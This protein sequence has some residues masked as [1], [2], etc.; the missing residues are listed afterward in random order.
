YYFLSQWLRLP[1]L[2]DRSRGYWRGVLNRILFVRPIFDAARYGRR[3]RMIYLVFGLLSFVYNVA[4]ALLILIFVGG[5]LIDRFYLL[6]LLLAAGIGLI[7]MRRPISQTI[8]MFVVPAS[9][10][11]AILRSIRLKPGLQTKEDK[12]ADDNQTTSQTSEQSAGKGSRSPFWR[13][14]LVPLSIALLVITVLLAPW[15]ASV[16][17]YG[18]LVAIPAREA[19]IRAPESATLIF[20]NAQPGAQLAAGASIGRMGNYDLEDQI[21]Q[22]QSD[23]TRANADYDRLLGELRARSENAARAEFQLRQRQ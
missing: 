3:E 6:G 8:N 5:W 7:F 1:N 2:M 14:R 11:R 23:L 19:I 18:A 20:L 12:M 22:A 9:A 21:S 4:F 15:S 16:G 10:G 17:N 13:R